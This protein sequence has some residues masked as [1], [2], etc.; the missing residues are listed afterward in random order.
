VEVRRSGK[1][2]SRE[3]IGRHH[4]RSKLLSLSLSLLL[5]LF[6]SFSRCSE[7]Q[8]ESVARRR[9][10]LNS[11]LRTRERRWEN[12]EARKR[13]RRGKK[14]RL[15]FLASRSAAPR[16]VVASTISGKNRPRD[17]GKAPER[18]FTRLIGISPGGESRRG[19][20]LFTLSP[21]GVTA[22]STLKRER[23][24]KKLSLHSVLQ[25]ALSSTSSSFFS[26]RR[27]A[28]ESW[29]VEAM[30]EKVER[31]AE[32]RGFFFLSSLFFLL[33]G[34]RCFEGGKFSSESEAKK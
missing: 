9:S 11:E 30:A 13:R 25:D 26:V 10:V 32:G 27:G 33:L 31:E 1:K 22:R 15:F 28:D 23:E 4:R 21:L 20:G 29:A 7:S 24:K 3:S 19:K 17:D 2:R 5:H 18:Y 16:D 8:R 6:L 12:R 34:D 14:S